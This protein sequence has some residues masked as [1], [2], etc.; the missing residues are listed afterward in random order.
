MQAVAATKRVRSRRRSQKK[1]AFSNDMLIKLYELLR[2]ERS[3]MKVF[4]KV[5]NE[6][7]EFVSG[8]AEERGD[9]S[10]PVYTTRELSFILSMSPDELRK[11]HYFKTRLV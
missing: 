4:S 1:S 7:I 8:A 2:G 10:R 9:A 5:L 11:Y 6:E 3:A